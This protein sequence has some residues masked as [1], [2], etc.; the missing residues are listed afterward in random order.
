[1]GAGSLGQNDERFF[2]VRFPNLPLEY[3]DES[4]L[5]RLA[6]A[7]GEPLF[8]DAQTKKWDR[9]GF[10][11]V[12]I[13]I[14]L[15][16]SLAKGIWAQGLKGRFFQHLEYEGIPLLCMNCGRIGHKTETCTMG[17]TPTKRGP[18]ETM[19]MSDPSSHGMKN[20]AARQEQQQN[21]ETKDMAAV[22]P[23]KENTVAGV[24]NTQ[25]ASSVSI[26]QKNCAT[27]QATLS[28][29]TPKGLALSEGMIGKAGISKPRW[30]RDR[31]SKSHLFKE[32]ASLGT[33]GFLP[34]TRQAGT[35]TPT[36]QGI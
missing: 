20:A 17:L 18:I 12:C 10:A 8:I 26:E 16:R 32:L 9:C 36:V 28:G 34:R 1:M 5:A 15:S 30:K 4:N 2:R 11:R 13:R 14:D 23:M 29:L 3:W 24:Q 33:L 6:A 7:I 27:P 22:S 31:R 25:L 21:S 35:L 19:P